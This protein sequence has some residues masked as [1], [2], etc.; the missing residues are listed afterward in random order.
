MYYL[1]LAK[2]KLLIEYKRIVKPHAAGR[3]KETLNIEKDT[4]EIQK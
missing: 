3:Q 4:I 1:N 2:Y